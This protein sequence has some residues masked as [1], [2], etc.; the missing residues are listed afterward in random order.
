M[1]LKCKNGYCFNRQKFEQCRIFTAPNDNPT[2]RKK[3]K[4]RITT[5]KNANGDIKLKYYNASDA[6]TSVDITN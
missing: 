3:F 4:Q 2:I 5:I 6:L 1:L